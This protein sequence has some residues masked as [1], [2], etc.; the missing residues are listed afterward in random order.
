MA[1]SD[2]GPGATMTVA[3]PAAFRHFLLA[4]MGS[5][6]AY[7]IV[8]VAL[9]WQVYALTGNPHDLGLIGLAQF[10]PMVLLTLFVGHAADRSFTAP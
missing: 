5:S 6:L 10:L 3:L 8:A 4:R 9:G 1:V 2:T 7:Q